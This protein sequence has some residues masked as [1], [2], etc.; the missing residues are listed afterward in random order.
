MKK[1][2]FVNQDHYMDERKSDGVEMCIIPEF[3]DNNIYFYCREYDIFWN[4]IEDVGSHDN[5]HTFKLKGVIRP[6]TLEEICNASL[7]KYI[8][9]IKE[10]I[11]ENGK[12]LDINYIHLK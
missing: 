7:Y 5:Y 6:A 3:H 9:T 2:Y 8:D 12:L 11:I 10:L 1:V 4:S